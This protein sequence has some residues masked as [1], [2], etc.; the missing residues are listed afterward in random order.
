MRLYVLLVSL[1]VVL[2]VGAWVV[3]PG[4]R[5]DAVSDAPPP[6]MRWETAGSA[7]TTWW[8]PVV[9]HD[10]RWFPRIGEWAIVCREGNRT[11]APGER[12]GT[13]WVHPNLTVSVIYPE[14]GIIRCEREVWFSIRR[15][16][17]DGL[18][19]YEP[20]TRDLRQAGCDVVPEP[21]CRADGEPGT[22]TI[23][24]LFGPPSYWDGIEGFFDGACC[25]YDDFF[26]GACHALSTYILEYVE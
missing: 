16:D 11:C 6:G 24:A 20:T 17:P 2:A 26:G 10:K 19:T 21:M 13:L 4:T 22:S 12:M 18:I 7:L 25:W 23:M 15:R 5:G 3:T 8:L 1:P 14:D 9:I